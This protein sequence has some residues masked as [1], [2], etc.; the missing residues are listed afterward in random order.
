MKKDFLSIL[1]VSAGELVGLLDKADAM[2]ARLREGRPDESLKGRT[3]GMIFHKPSLRT[4]VS[5]EVGMAQSG[6]HALYI[7]DREIG[8][9]TRE[10]I[11][12][13]AR[14]LSRYV[15]AIMIRT[16]AHKIAVDLAGSA[17]VPVINGLT[18]RLHPCQILA[19]LM[20]VRER[21]GRIDGVTVTFLGDGNNVANSW[22]AAAVRLP[23]SLRVVVP[24]GFEPDAELLQM[25]SRQG[26]GDV[27]VLHDPAEGVSGANVVY[28]DVWASMG[29]EEQA[30]KKARAMRPFQVNDE[31]LARAADDAIVLHC[32]PAHRGEEITHAVMEGPRSVVFDEAENRLHAQKA[33]VSALILGK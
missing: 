33:L 4:R 30:E 2:K 25:A 32:L 20:T 15:N 7:E 16:F 3:L 14:V 23:F 13:V 6:G 10:S 9:G 31:L 8:M 18:D 11:E 21:L 28:T 22:I 17:T 5:F 1:D 29:Q 12:D 19:D 26:K 27:R 24:P